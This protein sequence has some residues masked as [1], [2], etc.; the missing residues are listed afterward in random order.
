MTCGQV[1]AHGHDVL[2]VLALAGVVFVQAGNHL[3]AE[4]QHKHRH[5]DQRQR[6][7][8]KPVHDTLSVTR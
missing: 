8:T 1:A 4:E 5:Q 7:I 3:T 6:P 2:A